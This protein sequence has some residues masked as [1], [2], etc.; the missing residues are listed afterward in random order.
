MELFAVL[1]GVSACQTLARDD[2]E[3]VARGGDAARNVFEVA[4]NLFFPYGEES[5][6]IFGIKCSFL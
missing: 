3:S 2:H 5:G 1:K 4:V 6:Y